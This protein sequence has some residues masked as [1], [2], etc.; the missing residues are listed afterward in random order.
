MIDHDANAGVL[1]ECSFAVDPNK[2]ETV[3]YVAVGQ[4]IGA[5]IFH[6]G[7]IFRGA[8][9][10]AG[11]IGHTTINLDGPECECGSRG[12]LTCYASTLALLA[13]VNAALQEEEQEPFREFRELIRPIQ[14]REEIVYEQFRENIR[15]LSAGIVNLIYSYN[16]GLIIIGDE[17][18]LIGEMVAEE[19]KKHL[20]K[21]EGRK[22]I[23]Q[24]E[25][26]LT[27]F[28]RDSAFIGAAELAIDYTFKHTE[29]FR[30]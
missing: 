4:G 28:D 29:L 25:V 11:E 5:G 15:Y 27:S 8:S 26:T 7:K 17:I 9:G 22:I 24:T 2:Y 14:K 23:T 19:I 6:D 3:V 12:C 20:K 30:K 21:L 1:A 16:P 13:R 18:S 10:I